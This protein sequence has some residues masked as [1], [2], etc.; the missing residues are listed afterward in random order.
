[1]SNKEVTVYTRRGCS[2]CEQAKMKLHMNGY[3]VNTLQY[4]DYKET[5]NEL[6]P[7]IRSL[8]VIEC[9]GVIYNFNNYEKSL[10]V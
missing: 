3:K 2:Q 6:D 9:D 1:M 8:P 5:L 7:T 4:D 10:I